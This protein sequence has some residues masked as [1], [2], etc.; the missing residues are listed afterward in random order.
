M[1]GYLGEKNKNKKTNGSEFFTK[2]NFKWIKE[3]KKQQENISK[4]NIKLYFNHKRKDQLKL[5]TL[6]KTKTPGFSARQEK[7]S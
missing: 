4:Y 7:K 2:V 1:I 5:A 6:K 3:K